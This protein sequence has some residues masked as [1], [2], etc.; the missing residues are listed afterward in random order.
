MFPKIQ[1]LACYVE[2]KG[3]GSRE[4]EAKKYLT[5]DLIFCSYPFYVLNRH[6]LMAK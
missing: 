2:K 5:E 6:S 4:R 3:C 1:M